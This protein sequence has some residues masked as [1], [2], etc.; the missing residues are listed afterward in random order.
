MA[1]NRPMRPIKNDFPTAL[2]RARKFTRR[3]QDDFALK[4]SRT[5]VSMLEGG[6]R[7]PTLSKVD[8]LAEVM[9]L[10]PLTLLALAYLDH[11]TVNANKKTLALV[12]EQVLEALEF[13]L[14]DEAAA[15]KKHLKRNPGV[16]R[17]A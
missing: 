17:K 6:L 3:S 7:G 15:A 14:K 16:R 2:K 5:Y 10:H 4:S 1:V 12:T 8:T 13:C 9:E 11:R